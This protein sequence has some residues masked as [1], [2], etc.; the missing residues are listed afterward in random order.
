VPTK[1]NATWMSNTIIAIIGNIT[2]TGDVLWQKTYRNE[3]FAQRRNDGELNRY[4]L[5]DHHEAIISREVFVLANTAM[6]YGD[7]YANLGIVPEKLLA[8][9]E[10]EATDSDEQSVRVIK[11]KPR[12]QLV[13]G[14]LRVAA[15][16]RVSTDLED[17]EGSYEAQCSHYRALIT[18]KKDWILAGIYADEGISGTSRFKRDQFNRM[19]EDAENGKIDLILTKSISRFARNTLDC[20]TV[21]RKLKKL[22]VGITFEKEGVDTL[23]G[24]G[25]VI[26]TILA[27]IAQ[28]ESASISQNVRMGIQYRFQRG[29]PV[30]NCERF[31][32]YDKRDGKLVINEKQAAVVRRIFRDFLDGFSADMIAGDLRRER[33]SSGTGCTEWPVSS[34]KYILLN[35]K[36]AG[37]LLQQKFLIEDFLTHRTV[38][39]K[40]Q[41]PQYYVEGAHSPIVPRTVFR[42]AADELYFRSVHKGETCF[43]SRKALRGRTWCACGGRMKH[44]RRLEGLVFKCPDCAAEWKETDLKRQ[45]L[46]AAAKL[47]GK[48]AEIEKMINDLD[49]AL[50]AEDRKERV[51]AQRREWQLKN[52][53]PVE[54]AG[55]T[56]AC[57]DEADFRARTSYLTV[58]WSDNVM[59]RLLEKVVAG[60]SVLFQG[61][62]IV[63][64]D[65]Q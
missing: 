56:A 22:G 29:L 41:L 40:G 31:L 46:V 42:R 16:C 17:Q 64:A 36:Y 37:D 60:E 3:N 35:E 25:E 6:G 57:Y 44:L 39:N 30:V 47:P 20:L 49:G 13:G 38:R 28:Q 53:L 2:Y 19:V 24:N 32:G 62:L 10:K 61:G 63:Y 8:E 59:I 18:G 34:V 12:V 45:V 65:E 51:E 11:A 7:P 26:L 21:V 23:D 52:L 58:S 48:R 43:G 4:F 54:I 14:A 55:V 9:N 5:P 15:Y 50:H 27:S 1:Y 33:V